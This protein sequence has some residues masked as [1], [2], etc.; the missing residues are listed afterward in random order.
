MCS[1]DLLLWV[2]ADKCGLMDYV[3]GGVTGR[4]RSGWWRRRGVVRF[5]YVEALEFLVQNCERLEFLRL[6]H[7]RLKPV[8]D[9]ILLFFHKVLMII[10]EM[11]STVKLWLMEMTYTATIPVQLQQSDLHYQYVTNIR[12]RRI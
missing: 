3:C 8:L 5:E 6:L 7:L 12:S 10:I 2:S 11:S 9:F 4:M 1:C